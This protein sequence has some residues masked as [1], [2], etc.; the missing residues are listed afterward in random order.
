MLIQEVMQNQGHDLAETAYV[1]PARMHTAGVQEIVD[2]CN[3]AGSF[4]AVAYDSLH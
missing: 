1:H 2:T 3:A 4:A